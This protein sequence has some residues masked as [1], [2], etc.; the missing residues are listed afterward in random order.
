MT[1]FERKIAEVLSRTKVLSEPLK[2]GFRTELERKLAEALSL[3]V[4]KKED[5]G[6]RE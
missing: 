4:T 5:D 3:C 2:T 6:Q 1:E